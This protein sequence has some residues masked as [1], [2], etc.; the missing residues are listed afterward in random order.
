MAV[1]ETS[2]RFNELVYQLV[3][4]IPEG[5]V[6][7]YGAIA[8]VLGRP[9]NARLVGYAMRVAHE[10]YPPVPAH[11]VLNSSGSLTAKAAFGGSLMQQL[12]ENEGIVV[13]NDRVKNFRKVFWE[14]LGV[15]SDW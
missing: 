10:A 2:E 3:R 9:R 8:R 6:T 15:I 11:R 12:L 5:R 7:S 14:P 4:A 1:S 13:E